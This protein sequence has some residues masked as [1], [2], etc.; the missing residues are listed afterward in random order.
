MQE[1]GCVPT[2]CGRSSIASHGAS[3][4]RRRHGV[5]RDADGHVGHD[6][7]DVHRFERLGAY[8]EDDGSAAK[9]LRLTSFDE[10]RRT[11]TTRKGA[12]PR[13]VTD[14]RTG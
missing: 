2:S 10:M 14:V 5:I 6:S 13:R 7:L 1:R 9:Q 3:S 11:P 12:S 8:L 4:T